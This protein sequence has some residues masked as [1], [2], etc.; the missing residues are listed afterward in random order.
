[1]RIFRSLGVGDIIGAKGLW[2]WICDCF[3][4]TMSNSKDVPKAEGSVFSDSFRCPQVLMKYLFN[5]APDD[6]FV[7]TYLKY[8]YHR[9][10]WV[11]SLKDSNLYGKISGGQTIKV[12]GITSHKGRPGWKQIDDGNKEPAAFQQ[13]RWFEVTWEQKKEAPHPN[14]LPQCRRLHHRPSSR[15]QVDQSA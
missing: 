10:R 14:D 2:S 7:A 3:P 15:L 4:R 6:H 12:S 8:R 9:R 1:M 5:E 13:E 11:S